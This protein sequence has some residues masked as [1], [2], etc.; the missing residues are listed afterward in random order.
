MKKFK[1][2]SQKV[3][4]LMINSIYTHK[5]IFIRELVSNASDA[6]DKLYYKSLTGG[7]S[8]LARDDFAIRIEI[9]KEKRTLTISDNGIGMTEEELDNNLGVIARSGSQEFKQNNEQKEDVSIIGQFGV[10]FYSA[11]MVADKVDVISRAYG[12]DKAYKWTSNGSSGYEIEESERSENGSTV[13]LHLRDDGEEE[14]YSQY[15]EEYEIKELIKKY[16]DYIRYPIRMETTHYKTEGEGENA[17]ETEYKEEETL[18]SMI[19]LWKKSKSEVTEEEYNQFY[20]D[21]FY[22]MENPAKVIHT[23]AEGAVDY[24]A[25]LYIPSHPQFN[26]YTKNY[27]KGLKLYTNGV[28][29]TDCCK[30]LLPD[31][32]GFVKGLVDSELTLNVSRETIQ[33]DRQ[34]KK[35][36]SNL[37]K[38]IKSE[39]T[40]LLESDREK[41][42]AFYKG[43]ATQLKYGIYDN[44]GANKETLKDL[45]LFYSAK[46]DK[47]VTLKEYADK[48]GESQKYIY[49]ATG[50]TE[51]SVKAL[52][53]C[54][55][56]LDAGYDILCL[57]EDIDEF[58]LRILGTFNE[59]EFRS[60][61]DS[62]LGLDETEAV[63]ENKVLTDFMQEKLAGKVVEVKISSRLK[64][65]PVCFSTKGELSM[66]MEKVLNKL[67]DAPQG[68][69]KAQKVLEINGNHP[70]YEKLQSALESDKEKLEKLTEVLYCQA[71]LIEGMPIESP[72]HLT[73]LICS[74]L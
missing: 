13:I 66:E 21:N 25:L 34:L 51:E 35:I 45:V 64:S 10:G 54:E 27:E 4:D 39:L 59:K 53:Q 6:I 20:K 26:Y 19:P 15:L 14:K 41:Y 32:F 67:P 56:V 28:L 17:K 73:E 44:W 47:L 2:E 70:I 63:I 22:D 24:K 33:H 38:K 23:S 9:D 11:F 49:Y 60:V 37:E 3:L 5:E 71:M 18:N 8:G 74:L 36:A 31:Y 46:E 29:I 7:V 72:T 52:P 40:A 65:H 55:K 50:S 62:D 57:T 69:V 1:T 42:L 68:G 43:F 12:Q 30:D 58:A 16:S 61:T 48:M